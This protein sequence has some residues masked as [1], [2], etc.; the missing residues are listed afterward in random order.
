MRRITK[1]VFVFAIIVSLIGVQSP[2][3]AQNMLRKLGRGT[4]NV[5]TSIFEFPKS[6]QEQLYDEGVI[7]AGT[8]GI[9]D[10]AY[11]FLVRTVV[12]AFEIV[13][14]PIP[15]PEDYAPIVE[16]EFLFSP[17]DEFVVGGYGY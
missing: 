11:K 16:P 7:A 17:D 14:F 6:I 10:G 3:F 4:S 13:T 15:F 12:G 1:A 9:L 8:Y 2:C 5:L